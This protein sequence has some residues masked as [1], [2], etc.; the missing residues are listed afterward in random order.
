MS[1]DSDEEPSLTTELGFALEET[2][3]MGTVEGIKASVQGWRNR[4]RLDNGLVFLINLIC[5]AVGVSVLQQYTGLVG[6][7]GIALAVV[8]TLG[9]LDQLIGRIL[10]WN[11]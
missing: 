11:Q 1:D 2:Q 9:L 5:L 10:L 7:V 3:A 6:W 4:L 8:G